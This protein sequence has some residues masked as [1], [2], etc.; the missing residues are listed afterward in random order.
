VYT[1]SQQE[2]CAIDARYISSRRAF[3]EIWPFEIIF[4]WICSNRK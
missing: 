2:S 4:T 3:A 1:L